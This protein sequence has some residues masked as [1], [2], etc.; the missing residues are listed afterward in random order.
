MGVTMTEREIGFLSQVV[1]A[2]CN[3]VSWLVL[4]F[5]KLTYPIV[6][7]TSIATI[8]KATIYFLNPYKLVF[9]MQ[10]SFSKSKQNSVLASLV[11]QKTIIREIPVQ[12]LS[13]ILFLSQESDHFIK[14]EITCLPFVI[15]VL[16][17]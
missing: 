10:I 6:L 4:P 13:I 9:L 1:P 15:F 7:V 2:G 5:C 3:Y 16:S 11:E 14:N 8:V 12:I 17:C